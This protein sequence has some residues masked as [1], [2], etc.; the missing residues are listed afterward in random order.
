MPDTIEI[1]AKPKFCTDWHLKRKIHS[2]IC[3]NEV[4]RWCTCADLHAVGSAQLVLR[5]D[6]G[7]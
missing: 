7:H 5:N 4:V 3:R 6:K 1:T 2:L